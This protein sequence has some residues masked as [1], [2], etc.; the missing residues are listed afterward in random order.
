M[1]IG[2]FVISD[3]IVCT[4]AS[5]GLCN[6]ALATVF[7]TQ[8]QFSVGLIGTSKGSTGVP[9]NYW[10][11]FNLT[12]AQDASIR[13]ASSGLI[14]SSAMFIYDATV[15]SPDSV[16]SAMNLKR[17]TGATVSDPVPD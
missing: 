11:Y 14:S 8:T 9:T 2:I 4:A 7:P 3:L 5:S 13:T 12:S 16:L 6:N 1:P 15:T 17:C 10:A